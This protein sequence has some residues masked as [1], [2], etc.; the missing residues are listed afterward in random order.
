MGVT[1]LN[2]IAYVSSKGVAGDIVETVKVITCQCCSTNRMPGR[3]H[4]SMAVACQFHFS[5]VGAKHAGLHKIV[6]GSQGW[7]IRR[8]LAL[9]SK[10]ESFAL[11]GARGSTAQH[12]YNSRRASL[13][14]PGGRIAVD[15]GIVTNCSFKAFSTNY[16][17]A[18][19]ILPYRVIFAPR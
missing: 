18:T 3:C 9:S 11:S 1:K 12:P 16:A 8:N 2:T 7:G 14:S 5:C 6:R 4:V 13:I 17:R 10:L 19:L 15:R